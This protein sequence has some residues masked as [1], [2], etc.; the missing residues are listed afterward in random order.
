MCSQKLKFWTD[1][2]ART[3]IIGGGKT[4]ID[5]ILYLIENDVTP[6]NI[7]WIVPNDSWF[8]VRDGFQDISHF[9]AFWIFQTLDNIITSKD[10]NEVYKRG[11]K[12]GLFM[13]LDTRCFILLLF[14]WHWYF[15]IKFSFY[16]KA[17][18]FGSYLPL[19]LIFT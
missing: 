2:Y 16:E 11:E 13:R 3:L 5:A 14:F 9:C 19:D 6:E 7:Q 17:T 1:L 15:L 10:V 8:I 4:G 18:E 12:L